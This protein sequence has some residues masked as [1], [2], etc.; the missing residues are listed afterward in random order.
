VGVNLTR[1]EFDVLLK[2][3]QSSSGGVRYDDLTKWLSQYEPMY[4]LLGLMGVY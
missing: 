2:Q 4:V 3:V 1:A